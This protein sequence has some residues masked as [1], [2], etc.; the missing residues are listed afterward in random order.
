MT[1]QNKN[2]RI[3]FI[4]AICF[5]FIISIFS[6][7]KINSLIE[8][9]ALVN[10]TT[11]VTLDLEKVIGSL[12]DAETGQRGYLLTHD[13]KFLESFIK[14][15][16]EY[17]QNIK[18]VKQL[19]IDNPDQQKSLSTV[20]QLAQNR[21]GYMR[22]ILEVDKLRRPTTTELLIGK[23][24]MDSLRTEINMIIARED[25]LMQHRTNQLYKQTMI[26]PA[27]LLILSLMALAI[28][29]ISYWQLNKSL[30][31][32][33]LL[34]AVAIQQA[35]QFEKTKEI[36]D[37]EKRYNM[38]LMK[39][40]FCFGVIKGKDMII[41]LANTAI[42][43]VWAKGV[44]IEGKPFL[45]ILPELIN[46]S[47]PNLIQN[48]MTTGLPYYG[49][50]MLAQINRNGALEDGYF[51]FVYQ[52]YYESDET[53]S[54]VTII[55]IE[56]T[57][58]VK[59]KKHLEE[60]E[61]RF[62]NMVEQAPVA[63]CVLRGEN[64]VVEVANEKQLK[65]WDKTKEQV[66]NIP[67]FTAIPEGEGQGYEQLINEVFTTG[68]PFIANEL[69]TI[70]TRNGKKETFYT[71]FI[72]EPLYDSEHKINGVISVATNVTEQVVARKQV[73]ES[74]QR[75]QAAIEAVEGI[76]WTNNGKGEMEGEQ[77]GWASLTGQTYEE[78]Q[79]YGWAKA[80]HSDDAQPTGMYGTKQ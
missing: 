31:Q 59:A 48:V 77:P 45:E 44:D 74:E 34:K 29:I 3:A 5:V 32:A 4:A 28:L 46:T 25:S 47:F 43:E 30:V 23:S 10:H 36:Q 16:K 57:K 64:Y 38:M 71:N 65:L 80:V 51:N 6:Y 22:K 56:V 70:L 7:T 12:K 21:E 20:E 69:P 60:S 17:P 9:A 42:K 27:M 13:K 66:L 68:K 40:P 18:N 55:A 41:T 37:S 54:G 2:L 49:Y 39:S 19:I 1:T 61:M 62:R 72:Y 73:E 63:I 52:P 26:A 33:Q 50:D 15:L 79:G 53:I 11:Q 8:S 24:I 78:Y 14:G 76:L 35:V 58:E 75:F 67:I